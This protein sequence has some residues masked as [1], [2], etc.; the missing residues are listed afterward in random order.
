ML[1]SPPRKGRRSSLICLI[2][3]KAFSKPNGFEMRPTTATLSFF[4]RTLAGRFF[5]PMN[6]HI[7]TSVIIDSGKGGAPAVSVCVTVFN[8]R[9][10]I[11]ETLDSVHAQ[12]AP[13]IEL[14][15]VDDASTDDSLELC[16]R[17]LQVHSARFTR[18]VLLKHEANAHLCHA[19]N[20]A[21]QYASAES[22]FILDADNVLY[23][24]CLDRSL[25]ALAHTDAWFTY[26][27]LEVFGASSGF[28][29]NYPWNPKRLANGNY[30]DAMA[31]IRRERLIQ[32]SG[33]EEMSGWEDFDLWCKFHEAGGSGLHIPE[34][35]AR[36]RTHLRSMLRTLTNTRSQL[37]QNRTRMMAKHPWLTLE[38]STAGW[39]HWLQSRRKEFRQS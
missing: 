13:L 18:A 25:E 16:R 6:N 1:P 19:R 22:I 15:I 14:V 20:T 36:Y 35:L 37:W 29:G 9:S 27:I 26:S 5:H 31:L 17:W 21:A 32:V 30:I 28:I 3:R 24:R 12:T 34:V 10:F 11:T 33:Y 23:P 2:H 8:Y 39:R 38:D 4:Q 7:P